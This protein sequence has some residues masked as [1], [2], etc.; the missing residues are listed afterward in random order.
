MRGFHT[1]AASALALVATPALAEA[2]DEAAG[3]EAAVTAF[4]TAFD[5]QDAE[6]M[7]AHIIEGTSVTVIEEREGED[8]VRAVPL[9]GLV[10]TIAASQNDLAEPIWNLRSVE[11]GPVATVLA[12]YEFLVDGER[13]HCGTNILNLV[14]VEGVWKIAGIAYSHRE[15]GCEGAPQ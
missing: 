1:I 9:D 2:H 8:R 5:A 11:D 14:R 4:M 12:D 7:R 6:A 3:P 13:S 10:A 15:E